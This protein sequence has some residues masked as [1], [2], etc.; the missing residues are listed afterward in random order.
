MTNSPE[1]TALITGG[2]GSVGES[3]VAG[4]TEMGY[5]V[6]FLYHRSESRARVMATRFGA[7]PIQADLSGPVNLANREIDILVNNAA[8]N[9]TSELTGDLPLTKW[10]RTITLNLTAPFLL[11]QQCL[12]HMVQRN[13]GRIVNISSIYGLRSVESNLPYTV[14]KHGLSGLTK[15]VAREYGA[16]GITCNEICPGPMKSRLLDRICAESVAESGR[17]I[18]EYMRE[19]EEELPTGKLVLPSAVTQMALLLAS[20]DCESVNGSSVVIDG[21]MIA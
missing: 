2:T 7:T 6:S 12:P 19:V 4:F 21:G 13:W 20:D 16:R 3:L 11:I 14:S 15:T 10:D 9:E 5:R 17:D 18:E 8:I 1:R